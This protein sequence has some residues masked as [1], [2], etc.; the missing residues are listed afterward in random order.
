MNLSACSVYVAE[1]RHPTASSLQPTVLD[2]QGGFRAVNAGQVYLV[3][4][5]HL[6]SH[7]Q[8]S[9]SQTHVFRLREFKGLK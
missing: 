8:G 6:F 9:L 1:I 2:W 7:I 4:A 5:M 3:F